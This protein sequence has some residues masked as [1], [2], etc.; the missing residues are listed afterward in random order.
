MILDVSAHSTF[1]L[2][3]AEA[4]DEKETACS[5][6][7]TCRN[8]R[9]FHKVRFVGW[10]IALGQTSR[11]TCHARQTSTTAIVREGQ[12]IYRECEI[13]AERSAAR[14]TRGNQM[15]LTIEERTLS[16][17]TCLLAHMIDQSLFVYSRQMAN[18]LVGRR[19]EYRRLTFGTVSR[20]VHSHEHDARERFSA[21]HRSV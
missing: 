2:R 7:T 6:D 20:P 10:R 16:S 1:I 14:V 9:N 19:T 18:G 3:I 13:T 8:S 17:R 12:S 15:M 4:P 11:A 5:T 21:N